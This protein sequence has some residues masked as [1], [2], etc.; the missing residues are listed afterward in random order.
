VLLPFAPVRMRIPI[1][2][3]LVLSMV[4]LGA[5][6]DGLAPMALNSIATVPPQIVGAKVVDPKGVAVGS[7]VRVMTDAKGKPLQADIALTGGHTI[8]LQA[9]A[10]GYDQN[11]NLVV[12][13]MDQAQLAQ[14][15]P[16]PAR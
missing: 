13:A 1:A 15:G 7:L 14:L 3:I 9:S 16:A 8:V 2:I 10:L 4:P 6:A 11:A 5:M 12:T